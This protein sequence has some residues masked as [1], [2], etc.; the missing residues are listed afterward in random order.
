M[1][2]LGLKLSVSENRKIVSRCRIASDACVSTLRNTGED[3]ET[4]EV[5]ELDN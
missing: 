2:S 4:C 5:Q 1:R 3:I